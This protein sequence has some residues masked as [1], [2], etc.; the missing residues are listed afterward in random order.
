MDSKSLVREEILIVNFE[1]LISGVFRT[2]PSLRDTSP[3]LGE[4]LCG[5][6]SVAC[7]DSRGWMPR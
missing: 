7:W 6:F 5:G 3:T 2:S 4:E 1:L